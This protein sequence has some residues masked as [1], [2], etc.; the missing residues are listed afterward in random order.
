[1]IIKT[2]RASKGTFSQDAIEKV[3]MTGVRPVVVNDIYLSNFFRPERIQIWYGGSG[4]GKSD[5]KATELLLKCLFNPYCRVMFCRKTKESIRMS[6]FRLLKDLLKRYGFYSLFRVN[7][8]A[9]S[10]TC[11][12]NGNMLFG[13]GLDDLGKIT[14]IADVTDIW[15]EEPIDRKGT[16]SSSDF[17]EL[18]RRLRSVKAS[19]HIHLTFNPISK[20]S[21]I[22]DYFFKSDLYSPF[23]LRTTYLDNT[24][25]PGSQHS[26]F[27]ILREKKPDEYK[28]YALG[29][30]GSLKQGLVFPEYSIVPTFP[31]DCKKHGYGL[32]WGFYPDPTAL[33]RCGIKDGILYLDEVI[34]EHNHTSG[35]RAQVMRERGVPTSQR[36]IADRNP[37]AIAELK[38]KGFYNIEPADKGPGSVKAGIDLMK[39]FKIAITA[40]SENLKKEFDNY[41]WAKERQSEQPTGQPID[42]YNH[43]IDSARYWVIATVSR[44][45]IK[46]RSTAR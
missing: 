16:V 30:W 33:V 26:E 28:V 36:I 5:A 15:L 44:P 37:E 32:D 6:Q 45:S 18:N 4:G 13:S 3:W 9:M 23:T 38:T 2:F 40:R 17:T 27:E 21:W 34:Y 11:I 19:N 24:F 8:Q 41:E 20:E 39:E 43:G 14:S 10:L 7:E 25:T 42:K 29:E 35:T 31:E 22:H 12:E 46:I 1:M